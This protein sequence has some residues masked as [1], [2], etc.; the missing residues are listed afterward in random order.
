MP[1]RT[2]ERIKKISDTLPFRR[3][4]M[5]T[6]P[7]CRTLTTRRAPPSYVWELKRANIPFIITWSI[8]G[9]GR[10][11]NITITPPESV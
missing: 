7:T 1:N 6:L 8:P 4:T 5:V 3:C 2:Y 10:V 9:S 11:Y